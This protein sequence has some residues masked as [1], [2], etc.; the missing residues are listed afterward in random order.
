MS[1]F[2]VVR[3]VEGHCLVLDDLRI[4]GPKPWGGGPVVHRFATK[5]TYV[6][7]RM[8]HMTHDRSASAAMCGPAVKCSKCGA[9]VPEAGPINFCP[10]CGA[11]VVKE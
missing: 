1:E 3:G 4:A 11:K 8:C 9:C 10:S 7:E 2:T 6:P 5:E